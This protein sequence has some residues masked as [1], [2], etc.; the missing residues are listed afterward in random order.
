MTTTKELAKEIID[1]WFSESLGK[2]DFDIRNVEKIK[3][4]EKIE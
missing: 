4:Y 1:I 3:N 2:E